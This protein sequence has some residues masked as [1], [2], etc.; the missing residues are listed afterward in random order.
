MDR[1]QYLI[2]LAAAVRAYKARNKKNGENPHGEYVERDGVQVWLP[3]A[4]ERR[5]CCSR[6]TEPNRK[7]R[8]TLFRHCTTL[9]HIANLFSVAPA[10]IRAELRRQES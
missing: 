6:V 5:V 8:Y 9:A 3:F 1:D 4:D 2:K 7:N 10:D